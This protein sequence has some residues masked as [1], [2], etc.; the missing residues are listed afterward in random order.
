MIFTD[1]TD[2]GRRLADALRPLRDEDPVVLGLP[3]GGV[4]VA[5]EVARALDAALDVIVVRK[6][7]VPH[8]RELAF[9]AIG[10]GGVRVLNE[11]VAR[12]SRAPERELAE[13]ERE[14]RAE[15]ER[16]AHR[17]RE[18]R[19]RVPLRGRTV[20]VV[21]DGIATGATAAAACEIARASGAARVVLAVPVAPPEAVVR[22]RG[23][24]D[25]VV[26]LSSPPAFRA[27]GE[28]YRD[29]SQTPDEEV[30]TLLAEAA[31]GR[32]GAGGGG[33]PR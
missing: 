28:W 31:A 33:Q 17:F 18:G 14:E 4:P 19:A 22:L 23:A 7:G 2:A 10:E 8:H 12:L 6:L 26:C 1:R 13:V 25:E 32:G 21:D 24:A 16:R 20:V 3:R 27:V 9:G 5:F 30:V 29:F 11:E 15:L